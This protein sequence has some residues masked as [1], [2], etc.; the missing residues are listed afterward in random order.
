MSFGEFAVKLGAFGSQLPASM[1]AATGKAALH[2]TS[3]VRDATRADSGGDMRLSGVGLRGARV[4]ARYDV[5]GTQNPV[6]L[7]RATGPMH[8]LERGAGPHQIRPRRRRGKRAL[9]TP[10][11]PRASVQHPGSPGKQTWSRGVAASIG[12]VPAVYQ[13]E[14]HN[15]LRRFFG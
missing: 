9:S 6:A 14:L 4:G 3:S 13:R 11:G 1:A 15:H 7:I 10:Y 12:D 5:K 8:F 2:V